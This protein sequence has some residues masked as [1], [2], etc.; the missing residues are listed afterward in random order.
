MRVAS[1]LPW[2]L[3]LVTT[4]ATLVLGHVACGGNVDAPAA[5]T[6]S[7]AAAPDVAIDAIDDRPSPTKPTDCFADLTGPVPGPN[8][9]RFAPKMGRHCAGTQAQSIRGVEKLVFLGDSITQGTP[10]TASNQIYRARVEAGVRARFGDV[11]VKNCARWGA[12]MADLAND[13]KSG[14][15]GQLE[16][17]FAAAVE[18]KRTLVVMTLGGN[19]VHAWSGDNLTPAEGQA[20]ADEAA[21]QLRS[22][23]DWL[24]DKARFPNGSFVIFGNVYEYTDTTGDLSSCPA[25]NLTGN[26]GVFKAGEP[27]VSHFEEELVRHAV[28]TGSD[29]LFLLE[30]FCGHGYHRDDPAL[31]CYRGP[32]A[33]LWF[34]FTCIHPTPK[35][36]EKIAEYVLNVVDG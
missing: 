22:A 35:G 2:L 28:E 24:K 21:G 9:D 15:K 4:T 5:A 19:D 31:Q 27:I 25:A 17:C 30:N 29:V 33:E 23:L 36:H 14:Q 34:D 8:Y 12:R 6:S 11:E 13:P 16:T 3:P 26:G 20:V 10:P 1:W 18:P 7:D 32:G